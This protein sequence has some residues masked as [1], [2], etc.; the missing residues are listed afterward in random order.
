M[1]ARILI[2][3]T[4]AMAMVFL[5]ACSVTRSSKEWGYV[6]NG[7]P[8]AQ[9]AYIPLQQTTIPQTAVAVPSPAPAPV[10]PYTAM[11]SGNRMTYEHNREEFNLSDVANMTNTVINGLFVGT[12]LTDTI[13]R[14]DRAGRMPRHYYRRHRW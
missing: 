10:Q 1:K 11:Q 9:A 4:V 8:Q 2:L 5:S 6:D 13:L 3:M 14:H 7:A 12:Y